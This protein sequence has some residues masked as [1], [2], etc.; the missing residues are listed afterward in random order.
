MNK[1]VI[2]TTYAGPD[3]EYRD[4][5]AFQ[6]DRAVADLNYALACCRGDNRALAAKGRRS[7]PLIRARIA[8]LSE[9]AAP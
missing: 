6:L 1:S 4:N 5:R 9:N 2:D 8:A 3:A 7:L